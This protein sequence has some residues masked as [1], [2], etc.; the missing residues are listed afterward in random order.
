M[1]T[2]EN[3]DPL[4]QD[5]LARF[6]RA[7]AADAV[8]AVT[9]RLETPRDAG[10]HVTLAGQ[11]VDLSDTDGDAAFEQALTGFARLV[12]GSCGPGPAAGGRRRAGPH[13]GA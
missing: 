10:S 12:G 8:A 4:Q 11:R 5:W 13:R 9:A 6:G 7:A 1:G 2:I 3:S